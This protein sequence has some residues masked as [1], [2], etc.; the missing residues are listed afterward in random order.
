MKSADGPV[1][2]S[3]I[4]VSGN[5]RTRS[6]VIR[7]ELLF[8]VGDRL[9]TN[10]VL[11][12]ERILRRLLYLGRAEISLRPTPGDTAQVEV[13]IE[14]EDL[15]SRALSPRVSGQLDEL[16]Y[17][18]L[19]LDY[20]LFGRGQTV[21]LSMFHNAVSGNGA[22]LFYQVPRLRGTR[23]RLSADIGVAEEGHNVGFSATRPFHSLASTW[24]YGA[25]V[26]GSESIDRL[27]SD[28]GLSARYR[29]RVD[30][31][32]LWITQSRGDEIKFRPGF[33]IGVSNRQFTPTDGFTYSPADRR[34]VLPRISLIVWKPRYER[35][36]FVNMLGRVEDLQIGSWVGAS[37]GFSHRALGSDRNFPFLTATV[38]PRLKSGRSTYSFVTLA[39]S[40]RYSRAGYF[41]LFTTSQLL[42]YSVIRQIHAFA[43]RLRLDTLSRPE[44]SAQFLLGVNT[45]LRGHPPRGL[46]GTRRLLVNAELR[47][48]FH[49]RR[50]YVI[51]GAVF[52]DGGT[53][54]RREEGFGPA[55][56]AF[57]LGTRIGL[58]SVYDTP[59]LRL[60]LAKGFGAAGVWQISF[61]IGQY[62]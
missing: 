22:S 21:Q 33:R 47:P 35:T 13:L 45:G 57:G 53:T 2:I 60:D 28:S 61:G 59:V 46:D 40:T 42:T 39:A 54:W 11:E 36:R 38:S 37:A 34:R 27:Y 16:S 6:A 48:T 20:N 25:S 43:A 29:D 31:A 56:V 32:S 8:E 58:P 18:L 10:V 44:D 17:R 55:R 4:V 30:A 51:A 9:D 52:V 7:R 26:V 19:A 5:A 3:S 49:R 12:S 62:F 23:H 14:V 15:Y 41:N 1:T 24:S 50:H